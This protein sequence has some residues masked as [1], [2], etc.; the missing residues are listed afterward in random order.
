MKGF[1]TGLMFLVW[2]SAQ[3]TAIREVSLQE[4]LQHSELVFQ[5][6]VVKRTTVEDEGIRPFTRI[7]FQLD[8]I[9]KGDYPGPQLVLDFAG[10]PEVGLVVSEMRYPEVGEVG[11]Y[12]VESLQRRQVNPLYGWS[13]G[14][15][16]IVDYHG[17]S[18]IIAADGQPVV[19]LEPAPSGK[20]LTRGVAKGVRTRR[21]AWDRGMHPEDFKA[22]LRRWLEAQQQ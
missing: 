14:H 22:V 2:I 4:A 13:Q 12:F 7:V 19:A 6:R 3:A 10:A 16:R 11:I 15:F 21:Q 9:I 20:A 17:V 5:G 1:W 8:E 18:T